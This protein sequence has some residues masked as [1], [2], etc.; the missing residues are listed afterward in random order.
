MDRT[1]VLKSGLKQY[2]DSTV[3]EAEPNPPFDPSICWYESYDALLEGADSQPESPET[4]IDKVQKSGR[5]LLSTRGGG[6]KTVLMHRLA[7]KSLDDSEMAVI[8]VN[9]KQ[10][11]PID[12]EAWLRSSESVDRM[13]YLISVKARPQTSTLALDELPV[14]LNRIIIADGLNEVDM[15]TGQQMLGVLDDFVRY[16]TNAGVI[17]TDR[18]VRRYFRQPERWYIAAVQPLRLERIREVL[19]SY[20]QNLDDFP[21]EARE[22]LATPY[23]LDSWL[24]GAFGS[25][26]SSVIENY[27]LNHVSL[28]LEQLNA[29]A[30][31]ALEMYLH[32][33]S[34][35]FPFEE[36]AARVPDEITS[37]LLHSQAVVKDGASAYFS[38]HLNH[39]FLAARSLATKPDLWLP[40]TLSTVTFK[41]SSLEILSMTMQQLREVQQ[42]DTFFERVYDWDLY[43]SAYAVTEGRRSEI[44]TVPISE[45]MEYVILSMLAIRR[46]DIMEATRTKSLDALR[47]F[48]DEKSSQFRNVGSIVELQALVRGLPVQHERF[49][50]WQALFAPTTD[51][52]INHELLSAISETDSLLGW[53]LANVL[54]QYQLNGEDIG[55]LISMLKKSDDPTVR[56]RIVHAL[57]TTRDT[58]AANALLERLFDDENESVRFGAIRALMELAALDDVLRPMIMSKLT[59]N[60][61]ELMADPK[62]YIHLQSCL[63]VAEPRA[64]WFSDVMPLVDELYLRENRS[65][66]R[67]EWARIMSRLE[68][69]RAVCAA[70]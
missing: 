15:E 58:K 32:H 14:S 60:V 27:F 23:F 34:R 25:N 20:G 53:T 38:H 52:H 2:L 13:N 31:A 18:L 11:T 44:A 17:I 42:A 16:A 6:A 39:D 33:K 19:T 43:A 21:E 57:G 40:E 30:D 28:G 37:K 61:E 55:Y 56:W 4:L 26:S 5:V 9:L 35:S 67:Q 41:G 62:P 46:W 12:T 69:R 29:T 70:C 64:G 49:K 68:E 1:A 8:I 48:A 3:H 7:R 51:L 63:F 50:K 47:V 36:F 45:E 24:K 10:W 54:R 65:S 59:E 66:Y 22:L